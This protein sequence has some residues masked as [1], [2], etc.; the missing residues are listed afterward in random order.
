MGFK[1]LVQ[2]PASSDPYHNGG[3][4][5]FGPDGKLYVFIGDGHNDAN[6]QDRTAN[7]RGKMLRMDP[8]GSIPATNPFKGSRIWCLR[9]PQLVRVHVRPP[10][11]SLVGDRERPRVQRRD[12]PARQ[13]RE[14]RVGGEQS[15]GSLPTPRDTNNSGPKPRHM[16]K[17]VVH[18][19]DD[20]I[21][22]QRVLRR[23]R[24]RGAV[25]GQDVLRVRERQRRTA[26]GGAERGAHG[27]KRSVVVVFNSPGGSIYSMERAPNG[28]IYFSDC[29]GDLPAGSRVGRGP[30][31]TRPAAGDRRGS[32]GHRPAETDHR[33]RP[34]TI[35]LPGDR[36]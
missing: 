21:T 34:A 19:H 4:I 16:P 14:L 23:L 5:L 8:D 27:R 20:R 12:Q 22:G 6:A 9:R 31:D 24:T 10:D 13:A 26:R 25:R 2:S 28:R 18:G 1:A 30:S 33:D 7:L 35:P 32:H 29:I 3:R 15:C 36:A 11:R 17:L